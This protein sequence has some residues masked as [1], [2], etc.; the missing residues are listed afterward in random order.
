M[1]TEKQAK[2]YI[3]EMDELLTKLK[4]GDIG[5]DEANSMARIMSERAKLLKNQIT[6]ADRCG[7]IE[8]LSSFYGV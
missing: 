3:S 4:K 8:T 5:V 7:R 6:V 2:D 1:R